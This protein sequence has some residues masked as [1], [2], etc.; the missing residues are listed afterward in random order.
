MNNSCFCA[1]VS[2]STKSCANRVGL[3]LLNYGNFSIE[4]LLTALRKGKRICTHSLSN[5]SSY[6]H[7]SSSFHLFISFFRLMLSSQECVKS[8]VYSILD[9]DGVG[10]DD[11]LKAEWDM[12]VDHSSTEKENS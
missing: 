5:F 7:L 10:G 4:D 11:N 8:T 2:F 9:L 12:R 6:S 1:T 3:S